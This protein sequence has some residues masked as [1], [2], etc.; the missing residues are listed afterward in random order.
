[1]DRF[2]ITIKQVIIHKLVDGVFFSS[3]IC[4]RDDIEEIIDARTSDAIALAIRFDAP[5]FTYENIMKKASYSDD[6]NVNEPQEKDKNWI[7]NFIEE[8]EPKED[9]LKILLLLLAKNSMQ[10]LQNS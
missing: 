5:V 10:C 9:V 6:N 4:E 3:L 1:M 8:Q 7:K 2:E